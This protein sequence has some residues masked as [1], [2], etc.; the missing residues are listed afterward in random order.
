MAIVNNL[1]GFV[2]AIT[3]VVII[4]LKRIFFSVRC[5]FRL[6]ENFLLAHG[7]RNALLLLE[8]DHNISGNAATT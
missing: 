5:S 3:T 7:G 1:V 6:N 8:Y 2:V 4:L